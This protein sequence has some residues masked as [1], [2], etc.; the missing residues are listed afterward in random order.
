M[1]PDQPI[2]KLG[3]LVFTERTGPRMFITLY[4]W[5]WGNKHVVSSLFEG[6]GHYSLTLGLAAA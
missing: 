4:T 5:G 6:D 2:Q 3:C 1:W